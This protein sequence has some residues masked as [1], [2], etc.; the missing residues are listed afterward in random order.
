VEGWIEIPIKQI[1][2]TVSV[3]QKALYKLAIQ[4]INFIG[5][6]IAEIENTRTRIG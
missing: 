6:K 2:I 1:S 4:D 5:L 3:N